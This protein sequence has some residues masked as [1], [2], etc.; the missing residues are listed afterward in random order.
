[1]MDMYIEVVDI[2]RTLISHTD[3]KLDKLLLKLASRIVEK[4]GGVE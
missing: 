2:L 4:I 1:M 3:N